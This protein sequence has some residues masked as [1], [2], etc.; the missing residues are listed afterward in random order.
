M[1]P[2]PPSRPPVRSP[3]PHTFP[4]PHPFEDGVLVCWH[5][6][7]DLRRG[8][9]GVVVRVVVVLIQVLNG[10]FRELPLQ[11]ILPFPRRQSWLR[12]TGAAGVTQMMPGNWTEMP[13]P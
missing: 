9:S 8:D 13:L 12:G 2:D 1:P 5:A 10:F 11:V 3:A 4:A 7:P 6:W